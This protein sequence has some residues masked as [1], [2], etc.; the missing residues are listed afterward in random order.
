MLQQDEPD[1]YV[2]STGETHSVREFCELAFGHVGLDWEQLRG[3]STSGSCGRPRSTCSSARP[4]RRATVL[5][6]EPKTSFAELVTMMV[7]ADLALL[8][9]APRRDP[10]TIAYEWRGRFENDE[11]NRLHAEGFD[12]RVLD[13][14]WRGQ[15]ERWSLGWV[16]ARDGDELVGFVN[17]PWDGAI[18]AFVID[19]LTATK[20]RRQGVGTPARGGRRRRGPQGGAASGS[21]STSTTS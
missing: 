13:D 10:V 2:V 20:A 11:V 19:T 7:D 1:D 18:H 9:G 14:D 5:G 4:R 8:S 17:V 12:H 16:T 6:W 3:A 15:L 21:T